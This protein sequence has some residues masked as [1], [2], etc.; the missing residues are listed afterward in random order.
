MPILFINGLLYS[1]CKSVYLRGQKFVY[2]E[3]LDPLKDM[4]CVCFWRNYNVTNS[5]YDMKFFP[6]LCTVDIS[7]LLVG[8]M[9]S[10]KA[11][12][13][14]Y[15]LKKQMSPISI[16]WS[17][18]WRWEATMRLSRL[19]QNIWKYICLLFFQA[20]SSLSIFNVYCNVMH[21]LMPSWFAAATTASKTLY[22]Y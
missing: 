14:D 3:F 9:N 2:V 6:T 17:A 1:V 8:F 19:P 7:W 22:F 15:P 20:P 16:S 18:T 21:R 10:L 13:V 12:R 4:T 5:V 11:H